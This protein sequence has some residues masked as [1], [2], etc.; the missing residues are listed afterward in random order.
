VALNL[1]DSSHKH[2]MGYLLCGPG[3]HLCNREARSVAQAAPTMM[4]VGDTLV[5]GRAQKPL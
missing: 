1:P 3:P 2:M 5:V 4:G